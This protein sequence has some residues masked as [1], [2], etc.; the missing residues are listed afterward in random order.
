VIFYNKSTFSS[1]ASWA[2]TEVTA[3][4]EHWRELT[5]YLQ[6]GANGRIWEDAAKTLESKQAVRRRRR[7]GGPRLSRGDAVIII[8]ML[9]VLVLADLAFTWGPAL[10]SVVLS[11]FQ[12]NGVGGVHLRACHPSTF[13]PANGCFFGIQNYK[14]A[15]TLYW[16]SS[17]LSGSSSTRLTTA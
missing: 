17:A 8:A 7:A 10:V 4:F 14:Q 3:V 16:R 11:F 13:I 2:D 15:A 5:P 9:A 12:W 6:T 1:K